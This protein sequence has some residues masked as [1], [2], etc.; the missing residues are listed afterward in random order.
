MKKNFSG[1]I[2]IDMSQQIILHQQ[3][4]YAY[5]IGTTN[6]VNISSA[7]GAVITGE[8]TAEWSTATLVKKVLVTVLHI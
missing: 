1:K 6:F 2:S 5:I 3:V 4:N 7:I 8:W